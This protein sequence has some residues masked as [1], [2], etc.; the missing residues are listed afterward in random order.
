MTFFFLIKCYDN[1]NKSAFSYEQHFPKT[2]PDISTIGVQH[3][4]W[5][6]MRDHLRDCQRARVQYRQWTSEFLILVSSIFSNVCPQ[7]CNTVYD[8]V[9]EQE[10]TTVQEQE[11]TTVNEQ[12]CST[13]NEQ[14]VHIIT[15]I[16]IISSPF[17]SLGLQHRPRA[18]VQ[19]SSGTAMPHSPGHRQWT[20]ICS[21]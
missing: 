7:V 4:Q 3:R 5:E 9:Q 14:V 10:C 8:T 2:M 6:Q 19:H 13:V 15:I 12:Q 18:R 17:P 1:R 16:N 11:C 21:N 20:G